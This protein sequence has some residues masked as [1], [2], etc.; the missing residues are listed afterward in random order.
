MTT[1]LRFIRYF[2]GQF[3]GRSLLVIVLLTAA[4][5]MEGFGLVT[6]LPLLEL[7]VDGGSAERSQLAGLALGVLDA[8][9]L[10]PSLAVLLVLIFSAVSA[11]GL[12]LWLGMR[13]VGF[14]VAHVTT[15]LRLQHI[16]ALLEARW[17]YFVSQAAGNFAN[18]IG[19]EALRAGLAYTQACRLIASS[20]QVSIYMAIV[21]VVSWQLALVAIAA[22]ALVLG[23]LGFLVRL[24][25]RSGQEQTDLMKSLIARL[26]D[27]LIG[28]KPV[29]AMAREQ[30]FRPLL[31]AEARELNG[32]LK[33]QIIAVESLRAFQ[34][35]LVALMLVI[36]LYLVLSFTT[37]SVSTVF[38]LAF[39]FYRSLTYVGQIQSFYQAMS[40]GESA[41][42]SLI[43]ATEE[44]E[45]EVEVAGGN[46]PPP[47]LEEAITFRDV[48]FRYGEKIVL[49]DFSARIPAHRFTA[50][51]G[52]SGVGKTTLVDLIIGL[53]E[54]TSGEVYVDDL[55][56][57][58]L[59]AGAWRRQL[60]YVPQEMFLFHDTIFSNV[61]LGDEAL[62]A[63]A[64]EDALRA[65]GAWS[66]VEALPEGV[67]T[68]V[69][70]RG[71]KLSGGQRQRI[72][73]ARALVR[74]PKLL[75]LDEVTTALDPRTEAEICLTLK[76]L[77]ERVTIVAISHQATM[78][79][80][81]DVIIEM[82]S[83]PTSG[84]VHA[85]VTSAG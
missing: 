23:A 59:D 76:A 70:E 63:R 9:G 71:S 1:S 77:T 53:Y 51:I 10:E 66:F 50:L 69:G 68:V 4:G 21:F 2:A 16:R 56:L 44:A 40:V 17:S 54:P 20:I 82:G 36:G 78:R 33:R 74:Q 28:I 72:A 85:P 24:G 65:A 30:H 61:A 29:K 38:V 37:F 41:F 15:R 75:I 62:G 52:P 13:Q 49:E 84:P 25:R 55:P 19:T 83:S 5:L 34:E 58:S 18:S 81:A 43:S 60:G 67:H 46:T 14:T 35:P 26:T 11:K 45:R 22:S 12:L 32:A 7:A 64:V 31:E 47:P 3:P 80:L 48:S 79:E 42:W 73:I 57:S 6:L 27:A 8:V 39:L